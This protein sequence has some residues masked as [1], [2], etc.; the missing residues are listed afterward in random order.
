MNLKQYLHITASE[1]HA[2][3]TRTVGEQGGDVKKDYAKALE[4]VNKK[5]IKEFKVKQEQ[6]RD[7]RNKH[8]IKI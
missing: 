8:G 4:D 5:Y 2:K 1:R 7:L 6:Y 3:A